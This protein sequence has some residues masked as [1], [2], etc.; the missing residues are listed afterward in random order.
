MSVTNLIVIGIAIA[1]AWN[2]KEVIVRWV[3]FF[4]A[5]IYLCVATDIPMNI[6]DFLQYNLGV[7][8]PFI[9]ILEGFFG[10]FRDLGTSL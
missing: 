2:M 10:F 6:I 3:I 4:A 7:G 8:E 1:I 5:M 9:S